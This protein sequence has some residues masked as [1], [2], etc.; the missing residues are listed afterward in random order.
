L[1][2][3]WAEDSSD[4]KWFPRLVEKKIGKFVCVTEQNFIEIKED[5]MYDDQN[6]PNLIGQW[7]EPH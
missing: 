5:G 4:E 7:D 3:Y 2:G 6:P 1:Y